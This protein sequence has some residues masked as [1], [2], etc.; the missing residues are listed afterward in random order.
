V[1][2]R[3]VREILK[4]L[5]SEGWKEEPSKGSHVVF[6]KQGQPTVSVPTSKKELPK[7]TYENIAKGAG[8]K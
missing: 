1:G 6:R 5:R 4:R 7:G 3:D 8:W 2:Q